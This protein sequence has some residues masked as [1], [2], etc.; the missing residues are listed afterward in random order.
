MQGSTTLT[1]VG[2]DTT[3]PSNLS[4]ID[5]SRLFLNV[6]PTV[7][8][9][10]VLVNNEPAK[11]TTEFPLVRLFPESSDRV[12]AAQIQSAYGA[13]AKQ[14]QAGELCITL[15][16][17]P[18]PGTMPIPTPHLAHLASRGP[19]IALS[20]PCHRPITHGPSLP[21]LTCPAE[22]ITV[23]VLFG[24]TDDNPALTFA[25]NGATD[26]PAHSVYTS[27]Q[28]KD[29][30]PC[31]LR[32][33]ARC[34]WRF[35]LSV[36]NTTNLRAITLGELQTESQLLSKT[37]PTRAV[38][39]Y[40]MSDKGDGGASAW[41]IGF[42]V[43]VLTSLELESGMAWSHPDLTNLLPSTCRC[44]DR[45]A[46]LAST[47]QTIAIP[48]PHEHYNIVF[49]DQVPLNMLSY[50]CL[51]I[52]SNE[53][54]YSD[55]IIDAAFVTP[56]QLAEAYARQLYNHYLAPAGSDHMWLSEGLVHHFVAKFRAQFYGINE[57]TYDLHKTLQRVCEFDDSYPALMS[58]EY[59]LFFSRYDDFLRLKSRL[60]MNFIESELGMENL[61]EFIQTQLSAADEADT[62]NVNNH[63]LVAKEFFATAY[64]SYN[65]E[66]TRVTARLLEAKRLPRLKVN[67]EW[68]QPSK[69]RI[70]VEQE[71]PFLEMPLHIGVQSVE[72]YEVH[73]I[74][75][76]G[77]KHE[78]IFNVIG[79]HRSARRK[80]I[81]LRTNDEVDVLLDHR[82][83]LA[84][85]PGMGVNSTKSTIMWVQA[86]VNMK[87]MARVEMKQEW[88]AWG[89]AAEHERHVGWQVDA[90]HALRQFKDKDAIK[91]LDEI[92]A[93]ERYYHR[94]RRQ[95]ILSL[96]QMSDA[97]V[98]ER[99]QYLVK[100]LRKRYCAPPSME[101]IR[102]GKTEIPVIPMEND[103]KDIRNYLVLRLVETPNKTC[104][105]ALQVLID[106]LQ[107]SDNSDNMFDDGE[108][109]AEIINAMVN[110]L[111]RSWRMP[112]GS[113]IMTEEQLCEKTETVIQLL[114]HQLS[115]DTVDP[116]YNQPVTARCLKCLKLL[117]L[118]G[119]LQSDDSIF[120]AYLKHPNP[121]N[122]RLEA[123]KSSFWPLPSEK[124]D[125][126]MDFCLSTD[127][128]L[129]L[130]LLV[131]LQER[132]PKLKTDTLLPLLKLLWRHQQELPCVD[133]HWRLALLRVYTAVDERAQQE[134]PNKAII[135]QARSSEG[136]P[137]TKLAK[138]H[139]RMNTTKPPLPPKPSTLNIRPLSKDGAGPSGRTGMP[140]KAPETP[141]LLR[142]AKKAK[143]QLRES[144]ISSAS[145]MPSLGSSLKQ[146]AHAAPRAKSTVAGGSS[147][148]S[149]SASAVS[150]FL[151][152]PQAKP[153][154]RKD[155]P[156]RLTMKL[157]VPGSARQPSETV[158][159][160]AAASPATSRPTPP[161][162]P[163]YADDDSDEGDAPF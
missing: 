35:A 17:A 118:S 66:L 150:K 134:V 161:T 13:R 2:S 155:A 162:A 104:E 109:R 16:K 159:K 33:D 34:S 55:G 83:V 7:R 136:L 85:S 4:I 120:E 32:P 139:M 50:S 79:T 40:Y 141:T 128:A 106:M 63:L 56:L 105:D 160:T 1:L 89:Y 70:T 149:G 121:L 15:P 115:Y 20:L 125:A 163:A 116:S 54:L 65:R 14:A 93:N 117:M 148:V 156:P 119:L 31:L 73:K 8:I 57:A 60:V 143:Q 24:L 142:N 18:S 113:R 88:W 87:W 97:P 147:S 140:E 75:M 95:A 26:N 84:I 133:E 12:P 51:T 30:L 27:G 110:V 11:Y 111:L 152:A 132:V 99:F 107:Y 144:T 45:I 6:G 151:D 154:E 137:P 124:L 91:L 145:M 39:E 81:K 68:I 72:C 59:H 78:A 44:M 29:W 90:I 94:A 62:F 67:Y 19:G 53:L 3:A 126:F 123:A 103:F 37:D 86:D 158:P 92:A 46:D 42:Y 80:K 153:S 36:P 76:S 114:V 22:T 23:T 101:L 82:R 129:R 138:T 9:A 5:G 10:R 100:Y 61:A 47:G 98:K 41:S 25:S 131:W 96:A 38:F 135:G 102:A 28:A 146:D 77:P 58:D 48:I 112:S 71:P 21:D 157:N 108:Y 127:R 122:V 74:N 43:G 49:A 64:S 130:E 52:I 69:I